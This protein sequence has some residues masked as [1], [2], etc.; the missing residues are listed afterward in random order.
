[1]LYFLLSTLVLTLY[2]DVVLSLSIGWHWQLTRHL[3]C[4]MSSFVHHFVASSAFKLELQFGIA[5]FGWNRHFLSYVPSKFD[6]W[7]WQWYST[8]SSMLFQALC[9]ISY[10]LV[11]S[12]SC[13]SPETP[14]SAQNWRFSPCDI[15]IW[16]MNLKNNR[17][18]LLWHIKFCA[19]FHCQI[20]FET[21]VMIR[22]WLNLVLTFVTFTCDLCLHFLHHPF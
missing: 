20:W 17:A 22:K 2:I 6:G 3:H 10:L 18:P 15:E 4:T 7:P 5:Q 16:R 12:N 14:N 8:T 11:N 19:A 1:M 13:Y 21:G 9:L